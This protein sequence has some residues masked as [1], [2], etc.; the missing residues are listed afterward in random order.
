MRR[1][2]VAVWSVLF[3]CF[4]IHVEGCTVLGY[5][6]GSSIDSQ[7]SKTL[8]PTEVASVVTIHTGARIAFQMSDGR[9]VSGT[10][11]GL[12]IAPI[13]EYER[14]YAA[15]H[16]TTVS[17][18]LAPA[19]GEPVVIRRK[20]ESIHGTFLGF[21]PR[22]IHYRSKSM[23]ALAYAGFDD[24]RWMADSSGS[25]ITDSTLRSL[26][27][28]PVQ[29]IARVQDKKTEHAV[30]LLDGSVQSVSASHRH[31]GGRTW[32]TLIGLSADAGLLIAAIVTASSAGCSGA[33]VSY[34]TQY[35]FHPVSMDTIF[36]VL[37]ELR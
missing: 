33:A 17:R 10:Y 22:R 32:G 30:N 6:V 15:W 21:G 2:F 29:G 24:I 14:H 5:G 18:L 19:I 8:H 27:N 31:H 23:R 1:R 12:A 34:G 25:R 13:P 26:A 3:V 36:A 28:L 9:T 11:E 4:A 16:D 35:S 20:S 37:P 7:R